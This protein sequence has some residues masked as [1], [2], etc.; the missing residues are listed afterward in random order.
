[1]TRLPTVTKAEALAIAGVSAPRLEYW[2]QNRLIGPWAPRSKPGL[3][4]PQL[5]TFEQVVALHA[6]GNLMRTCDNAWWAH[7]FQVLLNAREQLLAGSAH[8]AI[9][10]GASQLHLALDLTMSQDVVRLGF[11]DL[12]SRPEVQK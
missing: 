5:W 10:D 7:N 9:F 6:W 2:R 4:K 1:M 3:G 8:P 11:Q 12:A